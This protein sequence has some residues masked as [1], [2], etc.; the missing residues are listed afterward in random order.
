M[1]YQPPFEQSDLVYSNNLM[2]EVHHYNI[3]QIC[4]MVHPDLGSVRPLPLFLATTAAYILLGLHTTLH[5][6]LHI[7]SYRKY[8]LTLAVVWLTAYIP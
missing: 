6:L 7:A 1:I 5:V 2:I 4:T 8:W 3:T